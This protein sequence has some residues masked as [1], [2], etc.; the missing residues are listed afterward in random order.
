[1]S[2]FVSPAESRSTDRPP[3]GDQPVSTPPFRADHVGSLLRPAAL[4]EA[5]IQA[6]QGQIAPAQLTAIQDRC[7]R[8]VV[9]L[10]ESVGIRAITDGEFRRNW[11]HI[12]FIH[13]FDGVDLTVNT[14]YTFHATDEQPP[15]LKLSGKV[16]RRKPIVVP[17]FEFCT[18]AAT[19]TRCAACTRTSTSSGP[20]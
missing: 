10:Q 20:T 14:A 3:A 12:D 6:R 17:H 9:A 18:R 8:D 19:A 7:I 16:R 11:W 2:T 1:M 15:M 4:Q 13:G 5:M